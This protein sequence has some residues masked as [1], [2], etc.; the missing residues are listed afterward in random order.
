LR[1][2]SGGGEEDEVGARKTN[3]GDIAVGA[4]YQITAV[5][6]G[7]DFPTGITFDENGR[8]YVT[9]S[10][11]AYGEKFETPR[12]VRIEAGA[13]PV[14]IARG[15]NPPWNGVTYGN[16]HFYIAEGGVKSG[17][18]I[19][20]ID[21]TG[22]VETLVSDLPSLGDHH[23][24]GPALGPDG[25]LY[26][27]QGT[28]TNSGIV[29]EDNAQFGWLA[30]HPEFHDIP[31]KDVTLT[32]KN[33][34]QAGKVTGAYSPYGKA[35]E[36]GQ[37]IAGRVPCSGA[38]MRLR[39]GSST[40]APELVAWGFRNPFGLSFSPDG[41]L[42]VSDNGYDERGARPVYGAADM[43]WEVK[44]GLWYGWP[45]Y[46]EGRPLSDSRFQS[47]GVGKDTPG[48]LLAE[49]PNPPPKPIAFF[50]VH[51]SSNGFDFSRT[52]EFGFAGEVFL[53]QFGDQ[54]PAVGKVM[55]PVGFKVV[56]V[57]IETGVIHDFAV[58]RGPQNGPASLL[59][60]G[61]LERPIAARFD[62]SGRA[63]YVVDFGV[64]TVDGDK[65]NARR[66]TGV[67][68]KIERVATAAKTGALR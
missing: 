59:E 61:G 2:S 17:G 29:G 28:A 66:K 32:G 20:R 30:R 44:P 55:N 33:Y 15:D 63:L 57:N 1:G 10:G 22:K 54:A 58:N 50:G 38:I 49:H 51:S 42:F 21:K 39:A 16:G 31:C 12:L 13:T 36:K 40:A 23:T 52:A 53:A 18:R 14:E 11:Y 27:G 26:F 24:D 5:A 65:V 43:L 46:S 37:T 64:M 68:W 60:K 6:S 47:P 62:P 35:T 8:A 45:D 4:D 56:R 19:L 3:P 34:E 25:Y 7:L 9:E 67:L 48:F 41:R